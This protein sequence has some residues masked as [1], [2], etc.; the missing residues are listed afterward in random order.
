MS[1]KADP[2]GGTSSPSNVTPPPPAAAKKEPPPSSA[3]ISV[4]KTLSQKFLQ[5]D[6]P[7]VV[8]LFPNDQ[9][10]NRI[11]SGQLDT[12]QKKQQEAAEKTQKAAEQEAI[13]K[14]SEIFEPAQ[15]IAD[16]TIKTGV[17]I[18]GGAATAGATI[19]GT[20]FGGP[21]GGVVAGAVVQ[22]I[23]D[24]VKGPITE[25]LQDAAR[26]FPK[27]APAQPPV[28]DPPKNEPVL[29]VEELQVDI[30]VNCKHVGVT[31]DEVKKIFD[32]GI[33]Q[34]RKALVEMQGALK[35]V[36]AWID[37]TNKQALKQET[38]QKYNQAL[39][40]VDRL[41]SM[42]KCKEL[43]VIAQVGRTA[44][45]VQEGISQLSNL[46]TAV[47]SAMGPGAILGPVGMIGGA[48]L[49]L[50]G[51]FMG[52]GGPD[53]TQ[54]LM[55]KLNSISDQIRDLHESMNKQ[56]GR[57]VEN[58]IIVLKITQEGFQQLSQQLD[59]RVNEVR[60][61]LGSSLQTLQASVD[62]LVRFVQQQAQQQ[63]LFPLAD[64]CATSDNWLKGVGDGK[65]A[66]RIPLLLGDFSKWAKEHSKFPLLTG[67]SF[68][69]AWKKDPSPT[70]FNKYVSFD[71]IQIFNSLICFFAE[72]L[73]GQRN[74]YAE[75]KLQHTVDYSITEVPN[76]WVW[77][78]SLNKYLILRQIFPTF[79]ADTKNVV[80]GDITEV[81]KKGKKLIETMAADDALWEALMANYYQCLDEVRSCAKGYATEYT[82][83]FFDKRKTKYSTQDNPQDTAALTLDFF[84]DPANFINL[85][86]NRAINHIPGGIAA[87]DNTGATCKAGFDN[88]SEA[89]A[90]VTLP[91]IAS[92][93]VDKQRCLDHLRVRTMNLR[94]AEIRNKKPI[95]AHFNLPPALLCAEF[96][97]E[98]TLE[99]EQSGS[100]TGISV[101]NVIS[102]DMNDGG[103]LHGWQC[104]IDSGP[105]AS[106][107][108]PSIRHNEINP[109][110]GWS[111][112]I[113]LYR[114]V[115]NTKTEI[116]EV[117]LEGDW[118]GLEST[119][120]KSKH[121][122][123]RKNVDGWIEEMCIH[124]F[125]N[126]DEQNKYGNHLVKFIESYWE[127]NRTLT[128]SSETPAQGENDVIT[129][130]KKF[131]FTH[132]RVIVAGLWNDTGSEKQ[133]KFQAALQKLD[134][135][136][137]LMKSA[138]FLTGKQPKD[139]PFE[140]LATSQAIQVEIASIANNEDFTTF[141]PTVAI[142][143]KI[144]TE[145]DKTPRDLSLTGL[146]GL[147]II[148]IGQLPALH[149]Q[150]L[151]I[152]GLS[153]IDM[154]QI[155]KTLFLTKFPEMRSNTTVEEYQVKCAILRETFLQTET[156]EFFS[157][158]NADRFNGVKHKIT[159][160]LRYFNEIR[161][162]EYKE[163]YFE[164]S[165]WATQKSKSKVAT[166]DCA[167]EFDSFKKMDDLRNQQKILYALTRGWECNIGY[168]YQFARKFAGCPIGDYSPANFLMWADGSLNFL[169]LIYTDEFG[170]VAEAVK[171][172]PENRLETI[173]DILGIGN[174]LQAI[175]YHMCL[176]KR[177]FSTLFDHYLG[178]L[179]DMEA[180]IKLKTAYTNDDGV[181]KALKEES[182][183]EK[184]NASAQILQ[185]FL[186]LFFASH[187]E[188]DRTLKRKLKFKDKETLFHYLEQVDLSVEQE[189][190]AT[191]DRLDG[192]KKANA[193]AETVREVRVRP[194][195]ERLAQYKKRV[196]KTKLLFETEMSFVYEHLY[197]WYYLETYQG[198]E[199]ATELYLPSEILGTDLSQRKL[200][201]IAYFLKSNPSITK[202]K[203]DGCAFVDEKEKENLF[204][205]DLL[206]KLNQDKRI[207]H[208]EMNC[209]KIGEKTKGFL[210]QNFRNVA[211]SEVKS[212]F[213]KPTV[214]LQTVIALA[215]SKQAHLPLKLPVGPR[216]LGE[217][218]ELTNRS[219]QGLELTLFSQQRDKIL[220]QHELEMQLALK[221]VQHVAQ[222]QQYFLSHNGFFKPVPT[223][224]DTFQVKGEIIDVPGFGNSCGLFALTL[225]LKLA[226]EYSGHTSD[227]WKEVLNIDKK[228]LKNKGSHESVQVADRLLR[229]ELVNAFK[230]SKHYS[231]FR[232]EN[233]IDCCIRHIR[234]KPYPQDM[235]AFV[236]SNKTF[237][238]E[239]K[240]TYQQDS[241]QI[242]PSE[243]EEFKTFVKKAKVSISDIVDLRAKINDQISSV[244]LES[245]RQLLENY[246]KEEP[247]LLIRIIK[248]K[249][250]YAAAWS[251]INEGNSEQKQLY[252]SYVNMVFHNY[253][254]KALATS[255]NLMKDVKLFGFLQGV[256][257][258]SKGKFES[259]SPIDIIQ[260]DVVSIF[261]S[262][263]IQNKWLEIFNRYCDY[264]Q[265][266][267]AMLS[268]DE[269]GCLAEYWGIRLDIRFNDANTYSNHPGRTNL[270]CV[271]LCNPSQIHWQV[272]LSPESMAKPK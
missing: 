247:N 172:K 5:T 59:Y 271:K 163:M 150:K 224:G 81:G 144:W 259:H 135:Q 182:P 270:L 167:D 206:F 25:T 156:Y 108:R 60:V 217:L 37:D 164:T 19:V 210:E 261:V 40:F 139:T 140:K 58:Q 72:N 157:E 168:L 239:L 180:S 80:L 12:F 213:N 4:V 87:A 203:F 17:D 120:I 131:F 105:N 265:N 161:P 63:A 21:V 3:K 10:H 268:A 79:D 215:T 55:N 262:K 137:K 34:D 193:K 84:A 184:F 153:D 47:L 75:S 78:R 179:N 45:A 31:A 110:A 176:S 82:K 191:L 49:G 111:V 147:P 42:T 2:L 252:H 201:L 255:S 253:F 1:G 99:A 257:F 109:N 185:T 69:E 90:N 97:G 27:P 190:K 15:K 178:L 46:S 126:D 53:P 9:L 243:C 230:T 223:T 118:N 122:G 152:A 7:P 107:D 225:G 65:P 32:S 216:Q 35:D 202:I 141:T 234:G 30:I 166:G 76:P 200:E 56:F 162:E 233:F 142:L 226:V 61:E 26:I 148:P 159:N 8:P 245:I 50:I 195:A 129:I 133:Q 237:L 258:S 114:R 94:K 13:K 220:A 240:K 124:E 18:A 260:E 127:D 57:L 219:R 41:G 272:Y 174:D 236:E 248:L 208:L 6:Q 269:L 64:H 212:D 134:M 119:K 92:V 241:S 100:V 214:E 132:R 98:I 267:Q 83:N 192:E 86:T 196:E 51:A 235:V 205:N 221:H 232:R 28:Q 211:F 246:C 244:N 103:F 33:A 227:Q 62:L 20:A 74:R 238:N 101:A 187:I 125:E 36:K 155:W 242:T 24:N 154:Y 188:E 158:L 128:K 254:M 160:F 222:R 199:T 77:Y 186:E 198:K 173:N 88:F 67:A 93:K 22:G 209:V 264:V 256:K 14:T 66:Y 197:L 116:K 91:G 177:L 52:G 123:T 151:F 266:E 130:I 44:M 143:P 149:P 43:Q 169:K 204:I 112:P 218:L 194:I 38:I 54:I 171:N 113:K 73:M 121:F 207:T 95:F 229:Q 71:N 115:G 136:V 16:A 250:L 117:I 48:L 181:M 89:M 231:E 165:R 263:T 70:N 146:K 85:F 138:L 251:E 11:R 102:A 145:L 170:K 249:K 183:W 104:Q 106:P 228:V 29:T 96:L 23:V 189:R 68:W 175:I 39:D